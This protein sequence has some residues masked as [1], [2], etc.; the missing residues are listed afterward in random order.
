MLGAIKRIN[1]VFFK[2]LRL[3]RVRRYRDTL[4]VGVGAAI[5]L[6]PML[7]N[8]SV[9]TFFDVGAN[10]GQFSLVARETHPHAMIHAFEPLPQPA[11]LY[12]RVFAGDR[13]VSLSVCALG[14]QVEEL[15]INVSRH[16][17][18]SSILPI[19]SL[20]TQLYPGT[21]KSGEQRIKV[22][23]GDDVL[24]MLEVVAPVMLK[25]DVQGYE[26]SVL[27][28]FSQSLDKIEYILTEVSFAELY[29]GQQLAHEIVSWLAARGFVLT[30][31]YNLSVINGVAVQADALF[32]R[33]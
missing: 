26:M 24:G 32:K 23:R 3:L 10:K 13:K 15:T 16:D 29:E 1:R 20:Q 7:Q 6:R 9:G 11:G 25:I 22:C 14:E 5:E 31:M 18:S 19:S 28:G 30:G 4:L 33:S 17:D 12:E 8:L 21:Q 2:A 27:K